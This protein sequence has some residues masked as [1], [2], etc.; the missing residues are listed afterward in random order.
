MKKP[1]LTLAAL[2]AAS[3]LAL[4]ACSGGSSD[5]APTS[6][7]G[8]VAYEPI[9]IYSNSVSDGR[10]EW[11]TA[12]AKEAGFEIQYVD[13]GGADVMNRLIAEQAN[14][15]ADVVFGLN[16]VYYEKL[17]A[18]G[19]L[20]ES[21][22]EW[23]DKVDSATFGN[24]KT[25]W[26]IVRE[27][28]MLVY[29]TAAFSGADAPNDWPDLWEDSKFS[30][31]YETAAALGGATTQMVLTGILSRYRDD[32][33]DLGVSDEGWDAIKDYFAN[34]NRQVEGEDLYA[35]MA[36]GDV[37]A[38][39]MWLAGKATREEQYGI[40][41]EAA[42]PKDGVPMVAQSIAIVNG[43]KKTATAEA[44][45]NWFGG[46]DVQAAWSSEFFT[47]PVNTDALATA[48]QDAV[49]QTDSFETQDIDWEWVSTNIDA[50]VEKITLEYM[51]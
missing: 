40:K 23:A 36:S 7:D 37:D 3:A 35:R 44:F 27:P 29:N 34:G 41:T 1:A 15:V 5:P 26:P 33:G 25:Y 42:H 8:K 11:L 24:G 46:A 43:T 39:Q 4:T 21:K 49:E 17:D 30:G 51:G 28:I 45:M 2:L 32:K 19:F 10:G 31:R 6:S 22:P 20:A 16:Q 38:G 12:Q 47:A 9:V 48:D 18:Q 13:L 14:P 50:W